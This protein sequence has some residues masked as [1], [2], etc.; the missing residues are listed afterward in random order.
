MVV[1]C[2]GLDAFQEQ[3][4]PYGTRTR[5]PGPLEEAHCRQAVP[6]V[7]IQRS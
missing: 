7:V 6:V 4:L 5:A 2:S 1:G 3:D